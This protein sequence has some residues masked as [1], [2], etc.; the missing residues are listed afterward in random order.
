M[1]GMLATCPEG[2]PKWQLEDS[3]IG[4]S[5]GVGFRPQPENVDHG[6]LI[7]YDA[8]NQTQITHWKNL[9]DEFLHGL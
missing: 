1:K 3:L 9:I 2:M 8:S 6:A 5:P 4:I 7:W